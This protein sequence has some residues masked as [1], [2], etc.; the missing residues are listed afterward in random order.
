MTIQQDVPLG[1]QISLGFRREIH[2]FRKKEE[3]CITHIAEW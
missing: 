3:M 1:I 2:A